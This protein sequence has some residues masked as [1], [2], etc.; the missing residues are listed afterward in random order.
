MTT[1]STES[2]ASWAAR[3]ARGAPR[4]RALLAL[5]LGEHLLSGA[6]ARPDAFSS[7]S[8]DSWEVA[9]ALGR[10]VL[11]GA[12]DEARR[13]HFVDLALAK[14]SFLRRVNDSR[15]RVEILLEDALE[16]CFEWVLAAPAIGSVDVDATLERSIVFLVAFTNATPLEAQQRL[17]SSLI[18]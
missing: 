9:A 7:T 12:F 13:D 10:S 18:R 11:E 15:E 16:R 14:T 6:R 4:D 17:R 1:D 5:G 8:L 3:L 2:F